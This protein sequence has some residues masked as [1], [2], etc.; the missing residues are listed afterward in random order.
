MSLMSI[1][2]LA[3]MSVG[4]A[5]FLVWNLFGRSGSGYEVGRCPTCRQRVRF[6]ARKAGRRGQC[7]R[8]LA[9][10]TL[11]SRVRHSVIIGQ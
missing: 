2:A 7:P 5:G 11:T 1:L 3:L 4:V 8:C 9:P 6:L 10:F